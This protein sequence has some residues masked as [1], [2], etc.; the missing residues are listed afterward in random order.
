[1]SNHSKLRIC[2]LLICIVLSYPQDIILTVIRLVPTIVP[3]G[4]NSFRNT[5]KIPTLLANDLGQTELNRN[6]L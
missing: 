3:I 1:M 6:K 4:D 2:I 5:V